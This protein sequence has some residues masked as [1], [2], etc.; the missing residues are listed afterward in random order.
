MKD[1]VQGGRVTVSKE[2]HFL[3]CYP[4]RNKTLI[5]NIAIFWDTRDQTKVG[6]NVASSKEE[7]L[8]VFKSYDPKY[9]KWMSKAEDVRIWQLRTMP[10]L[11]T[12]TRGKTA[13]VGDA[14]H[15]MF[16]SKPISYL[17][18]CAGC[19]SFV[20]SA[21]GQGAAMCLE[22]SVVLAGL[23]PLGTLPSQVNER[24]RGYEQ[25]RR[26]RGEFVA[27]QAELQATVPNMMGAYSSCTSTI[28]RPLIPTKLT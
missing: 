16:P 19:S 27:R 3:L 10:L 23:L 24:I 11:E 15:A 20:C 17:V 18:F 12:W 7:L 26:K 28:L 4:V 22:D 6:R 13:L 8:E 1:G 25:L 21:L 2:G 5:N 9:K 14:A